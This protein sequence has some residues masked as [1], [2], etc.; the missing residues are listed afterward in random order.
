MQL[1][2][3]INQLYRNKIISFYHVTTTFVVKLDWVKISLDLIPV[4]QDSRNVMVGMG[5]VTVVLG[6]PNTPPFPIDHNGYPIYIPPSLPNAEYQR[7]QK[8]ALSSSSTLAPAAG[9]QSDY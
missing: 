9:G 4:Q 5:T 8:L 1:T 7:Q 2:Q 3:V 6:M